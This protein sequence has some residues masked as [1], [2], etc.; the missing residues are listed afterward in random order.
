[1]SEKNIQHNRTNQ[2]RVV[3]IQSVPKTK[4]KTSLVLVII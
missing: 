3:L 2:H 1:V 4:L